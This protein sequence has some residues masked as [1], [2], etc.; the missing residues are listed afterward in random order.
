MGLINVT[1]QDFVDWYDVD[2]SAELSMLNLPND[3]NIYQPKIQLHL[4]NAESEFWSAL[5]CINQENP[6]DHVS[7]T[8]K[9]WI[10]AIARYTLDYLNRRESVREE[11]DLFYSNYV[12]RICPKGGNSDG[13][14]N[15]NP[16]V[17]SWAIFSN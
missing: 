6:P 14:D 11:Y 5:S 12:E 2:E 4:D 16:T 10:L 1:V 13:G 7:T 3:P 9:R 17:V 15:L 8:A